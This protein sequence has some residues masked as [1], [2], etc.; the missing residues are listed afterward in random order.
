MVRK[1]SVLGSFKHDHDPSV[2]CTDVVLGVELFSPVESDSGSFSP[3]VR[4]VI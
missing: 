4:L 2:T 1:Q 3:L